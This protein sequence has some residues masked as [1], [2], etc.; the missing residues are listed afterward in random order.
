[1]ADTDTQTK[2]I[3]LLKQPSVINTY[4]SFLQNCIENRKITTRAIGRLATSRCWIWQLQY[5]ILTLIYGKG[6]NHV[7]HENPDFLNILCNPY[8]HIF[9]LPSQSPVLYD[10]ITINNFPTAESA[11]SAESAQPSLNCLRYATQSFEFITHIAERTNKNIY[12]CM[13]GIDKTDLTIY[14]NKVAH[15]FTIIKNNG[16]FYFTFNLLF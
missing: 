14:P 3:E 11:E 15:Y 7:L 12:L 10:F 8:H 6:K 1:M 9:S 4:V 13:Y 16:K 5:C 2:I